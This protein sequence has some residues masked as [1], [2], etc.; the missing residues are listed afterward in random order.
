MADEE[1]FHEQDKPFIYNRNYE[2][3]NDTEGG[4]PRL[5]RFA[6]HQKAWAVFFGDDD[7]AIASTQQEAIEELIRL[8]WAGKLPEPGDY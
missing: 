8:Q 5:K 7:Q 6:Y 3:V 2:Q 1:R 4:E